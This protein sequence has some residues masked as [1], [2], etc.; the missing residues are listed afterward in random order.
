MSKYSNL[1]IPRRRIINYFYV[2]NQPYSSTLGRA[3]GICWKAPLRHWR[4]REIA[5]LRQNQSRL[6]ILTSFVAFATIQY[7]VAHF[8]IV[9][10]LRLFLQLFKPNPTPQSPWTTLPTIIPHA[11][12]TT[13]T[14]RRNPSTYVIVGRRL[15]SRS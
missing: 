2:I 7:L 15:F 8:T 6:A 3:V 5:T 1:V 14:L 13:S 10:L 9:T 11:T 12:H 4:F